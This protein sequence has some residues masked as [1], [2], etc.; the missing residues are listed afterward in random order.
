LEDTG[1]NGRI[2]LK[3]IFKKWERGMDWMNV[4]KDKDR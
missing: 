1:V 2:T 4:A 3:W